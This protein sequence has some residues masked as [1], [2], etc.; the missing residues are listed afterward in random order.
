MKKRIMSLLLCGCMLIGAVSTT[1]SA[2]E[3]EKPSKEMGLVKGLGI[4]T[5]YDDGSD[6]S[7]DAISRGEFAKMIYRLMRIDATSQGDYYDDIDGED[8]ENEVNVL[9]DMG[10]FSGTD[11][12]KFSPS[13]RISANAAVKTVLLA[14]GYTPYKNSYP[15]G[16]IETAEFVGFLDSI[17]YIASAD[18]IT[19]AEAAKL[20]YNALM[21]NY[22]TEYDSNGSIK[23]ESRGNTN[24]EDRYDIAWID[25]IIEEN[26]CGGLYRDTKLN[27]NDIRIENTI[28]SAAQY[29][30]FLGKKVRLFYNKETMTAVYADDSKNN[31]L[32]LGDE[33]VSFS[34]GVL[35]NDS[36]ARHKEIKLDKNYVCIYNFE[37][38][39]FISDKYMPSNGEVELIDNDKDGYYDVVKISDYKSYRIKSVNGNKIYFNKS[40]GE[41]LDIEDKSIYSDDDFSLEKLAA[42]NVL[43]FYEHNN[44]VR[45][46]LCEKTV[47]GIIASRRTDDGKDYAVIGDESYRLLNEDNYSVMGAAESL[48]Y[49]DF[50]G[51]IADA[52]EGKSKMTGG[53]LSKLYADPDTEKIYAKI[54]VSGDSLTTYPVA[55][56]YS[57]D[58]VSVNISG[59]NPDSASDK[60][61]PSKNQLIRFRLNDDGEI[62]F[63][64]TAQTCSDNVDDKLYKVFDGSARFKTSCGNFGGVI[65]ATKNTKLIG[66][67]KD[68]TDFLIKDYSRLENDGNY[69]IK[70]YTVSED[71]LT[72]TYIVMDIDKDNDF[73]VTNETTAAIVMKKDE[74]LDSDGCVSTRLKV[75]HAG[76]E[77]T[78]FVDESCDVSDINEG[79][80]IR[81][82]LN[83]HDKLIQKTRHFDCKNMAVVGKNPSASFS[84][85]FR[86]IYGTVSKKD[87]NV[88]QIRAVNS[89]TGNEVLELHTANYFKIYVVNTDSKTPS[90]SVGS[91]SDIYSENERS[92]EASKVFIQTRYGD[93]KVMVVY[94]K[95]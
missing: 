10:I 13:K 61:L 28:V 94:N 23:Y 22:K 35:Y 55:D 83:M 67:S 69:S 45:I 6:N 81:Y 77:K 20:I 87:G 4:M 30:S 72:A 91:V 5:P 24:L 18:Y 27:E 48:F 80:I 1:A 90:V 38:V 14:L 76:E 40:N 46:K 84:E 58:G 57:L 93:P 15:D 95:E 63:I 8:F 34:G 37:P 92:G 26:D 7:D 19:R 66:V 86:T 73:K 60:K 32:K 79:D 68:K 85:Y 43:S 21:S 36:G 3:S 39:G 71:S 2:Q 17:S 65:C 53:F 70:A 75:M 16:Y 12:R 9:T 50:M 64:D 44:S 78:V 56:R 54:F 41:F 82:S 47:L 62:V 59:V 42:N 51:N 11:Y 29:R 49:L 31:Y 25:G 33:E 74:A 88:I 52:D 89:E